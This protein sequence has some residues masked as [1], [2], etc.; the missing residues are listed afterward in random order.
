MRAVLAATAC[1]ITGWLYIAA[2]LTHTAGANLYHFDT[3]EHR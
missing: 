1:C 2:H 3:P